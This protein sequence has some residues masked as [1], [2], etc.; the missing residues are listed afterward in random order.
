[1]NV[2]HSL[3]QTEEESVYELSLKNLFNIS[4]M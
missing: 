2:I 4:K 1:M 3:A